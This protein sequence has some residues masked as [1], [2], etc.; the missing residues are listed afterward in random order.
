VKRQFFGQISDKKNVILF[1]L[2][3][4]VKKQKKKEEKS[5]FLSISPKSLRRV[6]VRHF[7]CFGADKNR[8]VLLRF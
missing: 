4:K 3:A 8:L 5:A 2:R 1:V 6:T 7:V